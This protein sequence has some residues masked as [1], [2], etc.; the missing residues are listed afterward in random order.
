MRMSKKKAALRQESNPNTSAAYSTTINK[1]KSV[2]MALMTGQS[3][4]RFEAERELH[5]HTLNSTISTLQNYHGIK[6]ARRFETVPG[7]AGSKVRCCR[8]WL[9]TSARDH[10]KTVLARLR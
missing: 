7:F 10:A 3:F 6:I 8:Y 5:D 9:P 4:N 2:L 1:T